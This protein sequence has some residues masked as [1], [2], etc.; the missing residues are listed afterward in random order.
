MKNFSNLSDNSFASNISSRNCPKKFVV[1]ISEAAGNKKHK[2]TPG[3]E[4]PTSL[5]VKDDCD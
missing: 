2:W 3:D 1:Y 5:A 4:T